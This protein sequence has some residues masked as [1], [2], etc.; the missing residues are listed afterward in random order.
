[1]SSV[2]IL[3]LVLVGIVLVICAGRRARLDEHSA[4]YRAYIASPAWRKRADRCFGLTHRRCALLPWLRA[5][6]AH[7]LHYRNLRR[8]WVLRDTVPL[9]ALAHRIAHA[10]LLWRGPLRPVANG[11]LRLCAVAVA[12]LVRP[13]LGMI[14]LVAGVSLCWWGLHVLQGVDGAALIESVLDGSLF[15]DAYH[16]IARLLRL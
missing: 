1:V 13:F 8:E 5:I 7:H 14:A 9:S 15:L 2:V 6:E 4:E 11:M 16:L 12:L 10:W 3:A